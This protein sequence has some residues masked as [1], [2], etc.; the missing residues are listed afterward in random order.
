MNKPERQKSNTIQKTGNILLLIIICTL[1]I[2]FPF[3]WI[4]E[5]LGLPFRNLLTGEGV[6]YFLSVLPL[7]C[8]SH[9]MTLTVSL[10]ICISTCQQS[11]FVKQ[12]MYNINRQLGVKP[13][14]RQRQAFSIAMTLLI[15]YFIVMTCMT[16][17]N[18][19][20][21]LNIKGELFSS[22]QMTG[23]IL[24]TMTTLTFVSLLYG[25][26]S[27]QLRGWNRILSSLYSGFGTYAVW[28]LVVM[29]VTLL[30]DTILFTFI[31]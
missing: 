25:I 28:I 31:P 23:I 27:H 17:G 10:I 24:S 14:F 9:I 11:G 7:S 30:Y 22:E 13:T 20:I 19:A 8:T 21:L 26:M 16:I 18:N 15:I 2:L 3:S 12:I 4:G 6:R 5:S 1:A 29:S